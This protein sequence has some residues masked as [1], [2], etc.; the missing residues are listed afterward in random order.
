MKSDQPWQPGHSFCIW[1]TSSVTKFRLPQ[2]IKI[3]QARPEG[4]VTKSVTTTLTASSHKHLPA[5]SR[6]HVCSRHAPKCSNCWE[7][8][9]GAEGG[10]KLSSTGLSCETQS[11][12]VD[13]WA[14]QLPATKNWDKTSTETVNYRSSLNH[15]YKTV[16]TQTAW[17]SHPSS[18]LLADQ[19]SSENC[20]GLKF[21]AL[22]SPESMRDPPI[23]CAKR[24]IKEGYCSPYLCFMWGRRCL[25]YS[26]YNLTRS[27]FE[28][29]LKMTIRFWVWGSLGGKL[30]HETK[31]TSQNWWA[32][33]SEEEFCKLLHLDNKL[34][35]FLQ[36]S[37]TIALESPRTL[38]QKS[39]WIIF[40]F[41]G[42][43]VN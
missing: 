3:L 1:F 25:E 20:S 38:S 23:E 26:I 11:V 5:P 8:W 35:V 39:I 17:L 7:G 30:D 2:N 14:L 28:H 29:Y 12:E 6:V 43:R 34:V 13:V 32:I 9:R 40:M 21:P 4:I 24:R 31:K 18:V 37:K 41:K 36:P 33:F 16:G 19:M 10:G 27:I 42:Y 15:R 22:P